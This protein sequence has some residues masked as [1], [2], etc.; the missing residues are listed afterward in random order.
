MQ[1]RE[2]SVEGWEKIVHFTDDDA[3]LNALISIHDGTL[4]PGCG[5]C[6]IFPY[7]DFEAGLEDVKRL[8][9]GM[10]FKNAVGNIPFGGGK[11]VI[12]ADPKKD[13]TPEM[14]KAFARAVDSLEIGR[15]HV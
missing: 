14:I 11:S 5:G 15:A 13:K 7:P 10:T 2:L 3:G 4:G 12:F 9:R 1:S 8:S 6:R